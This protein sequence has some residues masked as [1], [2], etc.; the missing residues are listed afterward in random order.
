[1]R[2]E[3]LREKYLEVGKGPGFDTATLSEIDLNGVDAGT[4]EGKG[5]FTGLL[6]LHGV[7]KT[8]TEASTFAGRH[9]P[10]REG[11]VS[12]RPFGLRH[13][14]PRYLG[15]GV[16]D[17]VQV[18]VA[19]AVSRV[20]RMM[21]TLLFLLA[22]TVLA[23]P[24][25]AEPTFLAKQYTRCT[26]CHYSPTGGG[27]LTPYGRPPLASRAVHDRR[28]RTAPSGAD[29]DPRGEQAFLYGALAT[30][31]ARCISGSRCVRRICASAFPVGTRP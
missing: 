25:W 22:T 12:R 20:S 6:T 1:M 21:R 26:A 17:I 9:R 29:D 2:N 8:V 11:I 30:H 16:K 10:S 14:K 3:H 13:R 28:V 18:E 24:A 23:S 31:S 5:S 27:L 4:S 15:V 19:F 7:R